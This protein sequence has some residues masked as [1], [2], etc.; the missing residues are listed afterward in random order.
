MIWWIL[1]VTAAV[2]LLAHWRGR[3]AVWGSATIGVLVGIVI[4]VFRPGFDWWIVGKAVVIATFVGLALEWV[5]RIGRN[6]P[7]A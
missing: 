6:K 5:P 4:A 2:A 3:N 1:L 7:D